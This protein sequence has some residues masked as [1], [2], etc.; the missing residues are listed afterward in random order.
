[1]FM[2]CGALISWRSRKQTSVTLSTAE[3]EYVALSSATQEAL[4][5]KPLTSE[6]RSKPSGAL[7]L[8]E[9]NQSA[10]AMAKNPHFYG[11]SKHIAIKYHFVREQISAGTFRLEYCRTEDMLADMLTKGL[12]CSICGKL[13]EL[14]GIVPPPIHLSNK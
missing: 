1:M 7:V 6:L 11:R 5:L 8:R 10:I 14:A 12:S 3:A 9:D 2:L 4:W 13:R